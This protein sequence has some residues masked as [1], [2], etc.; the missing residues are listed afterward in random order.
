[1]RG[2]E[3]EMIGEIF[4]GVLADIE[5]TACY[6]LLGVVPGQS[7]KPQCTVALYPTRTGLQR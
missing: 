4:A 7:H 1:V 3:V 2:E 5:A 6:V